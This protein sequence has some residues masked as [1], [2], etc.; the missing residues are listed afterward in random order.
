MNTRIP[1]ST[2]VSTPSKSKCKIARISKFW[3]PEKISIYICHLQN[4]IACFHVKK[5][6]NIVILAMFTKANLLQNCR[7]LSLFGSWQVYMKFP[8]QKLFS[9]QLSITIE[10]PLSTRKPQ[11]GVASIYWGGT[12]G[13]LASVLALVQGHISLQMTGC[14]HCRT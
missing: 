1:L 8:V 11:L 2:V 3:G 4:I 9:N 7:K 6:W 12:L 13:S 10:R 5:L 14:T